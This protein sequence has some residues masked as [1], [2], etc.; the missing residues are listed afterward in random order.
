M[1]VKAREEKIKQYGNE[2]ETCFGNY[3]FNYPSAVAEND[4][5]ECPKSDECKIKTN[6]KELNDLSELHNFYRRENENS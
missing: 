4:C 1:D 6:K 2:I 3:P 5:Y